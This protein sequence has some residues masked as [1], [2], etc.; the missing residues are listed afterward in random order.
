[1]IFAHSFIGFPITYELLK[2]ENYSKEFKKIAYFIGI[3]STVLPDF[4]L[5]LGIFIHDLNHRKLLSHSLTPYLLI[6]FITYVVSLFLKKYKKRIQTLNLI[7]FVG[8]CSHL[9]LDFIAGGLSLF[10]PFYTG[11]VGVIPNFSSSYGFFASYFLSVY[12]LA[13]M[14]ILGIYLYYLKKEKQ[15]IVYLLPLIYLLIALIALIL[16]L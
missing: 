10:S 9:F 11:I 2:K 6:F 8:V 16:F 13:E 1:M 4:D 12:L 5:A 3:T 14:A 7:F 15:E